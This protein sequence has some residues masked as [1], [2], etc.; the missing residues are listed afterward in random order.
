MEEVKIDTQ[1]YR[2]ALVKKFRGNNFYH[3]GYEVSNIFPNA[4]LPIASAIDLAKV[5]YYIP[6]Y[7]IS[8]L[9]RKV[10]PVRRTELIQGYMNAY[11][12]NPEYLRD[13]RYSYYS[14]Y[15][16]SPKYFESCREEVLETF[17]F[18]D[19]DSEENVKFAKMLALPTSVSI[20]IRRGDYVNA[21][22]FKDICTL[23]YYKKAIKEARNSIDNPIFFIFSN[24]Q[25]WCMENLKEVLNDSEVYFINHNR[26][27]NSF[28][29]MQLMSIARCN[30]LANSSFSW[31]GAYL[32]TRRD[33]IVFVPNHWVNILDDKDA[34]TD[35]WIKI[36]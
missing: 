25:E 20:H 3:N 15:W 9:A 2:N 1:H 24:D 32:N 11:L 29:D 6:N 7:I 8:K 33:K 4:N 17:E 16:M 23:D 22:S 36:K 14:G 10:L 13:R 27:N 31:W 34:Y 19:F 18:P 28:R 35:E 30:I 5:S 26:G 12:F 21:K